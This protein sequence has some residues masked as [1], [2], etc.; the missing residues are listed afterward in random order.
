MNFFSINSFDAF[1]YILI[2]CAQEEI[3]SFST[4]HIATIVWF[5]YILNTFGYLNIVMACCSN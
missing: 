5:D 4:P 3:L 2:Q 1:Y